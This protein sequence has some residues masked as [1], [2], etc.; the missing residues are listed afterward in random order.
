MSDVN[1]T[2]LERAAIDVPIAAVPPDA[3]PI[4]PRIEDFHGWV[5]A[6]YPNDAE[7]PVR[8]APGQSEQVPALIVTIA[9]EIPVAVTAFVK[10][11]AAGA[12][13]PLIVIRKSLEDEFKDAAAA[14]LDGA[15]WLPKECTAW[16]YVDSSVQ[17]TDFDGE[18]MS[19]ITTHEM[20]RRSKGGWEK[21]HTLSGRKLTL[22]R[23]DEVGV[24]PVPVK[25]L[26]EFVRTYIHEHSKVP[27]DQAVDDWMMQQKITAPLPPPRAKPEPKP[28]TTAALAD[29]DKSNAILTVYR[30]NRGRPAQPTRR[31][32]LEQLR[33]A[34][35]RGQDG[36][37]LKA[38][39][40]FE[41]EPPIGE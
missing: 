16:D 41:A 1:S 3:T 39:R 14:A 23:G 24:L 15:T 6:W 17:W 4:Q 21:W 13:L 9:A 29:V 18:G 32:L 5:I 11:N 38:Y 7:P 25:R 26:M 22:D 27:T 30:R 20:S 19:L 28:T 2:S 36:A 10:R 37:L 12:R 33:N 40:A 8:V 31:K 34:G 35:A